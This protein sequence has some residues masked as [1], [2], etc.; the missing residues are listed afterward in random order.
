MHSRNAARILLTDMPFKTVGNRVPLGSFGTSR[1]GNDALKYFLF[2]QVRIF[3]VVIAACM[4]GI[5]LVRAV[6]FQSVK[7]VF[8]LKVKT[9]A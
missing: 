3:A 4:S 7:N 6:G 8:F 5:K 2:I 1:F 9:A